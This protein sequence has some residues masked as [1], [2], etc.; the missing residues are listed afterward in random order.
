MAALLGQDQV[1]LGDAPLETVVGKLSGGEIEQIA[2]GVLGRFDPAALKTPKRTPILE[3]VQQA[4]SND[5]LIFDGS[6][7]LGTTMDGRKILGTFQQEPLA[8][9]IDSSL[10]H[11]DT[12]FRFTIAHEL[13]HYT[14]HR[15]LPIGEDVAL[16]R[17]IQDTDVHFGGGPKALVTPRDWIEWQANFF[18]AALLVPRATIGG[19]VKK[20]QKGMGITNNLGQ[21]L[22]ERHSYSYNDLKQQIEE[23]GLIYL[24]SFSVMRYRLEGLKIIVDR[25]DRS[26]STRIRQ[27]R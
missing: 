7:D 2:E 16:K 10:A 25:R 1:V 19:A 8:I 20:V 24:V 13:G 22:W 23:L 11:E 12:K 21:I 3:L 14:L 15:N 4:I 6:Q 17:V 18:A 5:G 9:Q 27:A 26:I